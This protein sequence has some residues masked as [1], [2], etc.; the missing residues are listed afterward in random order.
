MSNDMQQAQ[1]HHASQ[2]R[3]WWQRRLS[4]QIE[5]P[6]KRFRLVILLGCLVVA[7]AVYATSLPA[8]TAGA[9]TLDT[10]GP[11]PGGSGLPVTGK[12]G[13]ANCSEPGHPACPTPDVGW[14][15]LTAE[16]PAAVIAA[17]MSTPMYGI[18]LQGHPRL[19]T[20]LDTPVLV[21]PYHAHTGIAYYDDAHWIIRAHNAAGQDVATFDFI[22]DRA[23]HRIAFSSFG[24]A[25]PNDPLYAK[26]FPSTSAA[27]AVDLLQ[28]KRGIG[29]RA[30]V[31]PELI[32]FPPA[33][34]LNPSQGAQGPMR[35]NGGGTDPNIPMWLIH[36][37]D[38]NDYFVGQDHNVY[39]ASQ[40]PIAA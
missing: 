27:E 1:F 7:A 40:L 36:G 28:A 13:H 30:G 20:G 2:C 6:L 16:T 22:Y 14:A 32:F 38:Q 15:S 18:E 4:R 31:A 17:A 12:K 24:L 33:T 26:P 21:L 39:T 5:G 3:R 10:N 35:W 19:V 8:G 11:K 34:Q 25:Q 9:T 29:A 23:G 37:A